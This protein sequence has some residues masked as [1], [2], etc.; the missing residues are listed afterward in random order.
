MRKTMIILITVAGTAVTAMV[1]SPPAGPFG[2]IDMQH[3][4]LAG[5]TAMMQRTAVIVSL[6]FVWLLVSIVLTLISPRDVRYSSAELRISPLHC[7][8]VGLVAVTSFV[9]TAVVFSYLMAY[10]VG[11]P[12]LVALAVFAILTKIY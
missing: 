7:L 8:I 5:A 3:V 1:A 9:L 4:T 12:L 6:L 2:A 10:V 11:T